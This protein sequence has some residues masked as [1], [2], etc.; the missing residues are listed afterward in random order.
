MNIIPK[1]RRKK[2]EATYHE[3][4]LCHG[5]H[6][7]IR[8]GHGYLLEKVAECSSISHTLRYGNYWLTNWYLDLVEF[9]RTMETRSRTLYE[10]E[11]RRRE[12]KWW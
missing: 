8:K 1:R 12:G 4:D 2:A 7:R 5:L 6:P 10:R 11:Q 9:E 3:C